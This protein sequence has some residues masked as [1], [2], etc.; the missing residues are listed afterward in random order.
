MEKS[1]NLSN[2]AAIKIFEG[3]VESAAELA[4]GIYKG[5]KAAVKFGAT[6]VLGPWGSKVSDGLFL[7]T[8]FAIDKST[9]G[10]NEAAKDAIRKAIVTVIFDEIKIK[11]LGNKTISDVLTKSTTKVIGDSRL[12]PILDD[13]LKNPEL[14]KALMSVFAKSAAHGTVE[15]SKRGV[16][17]LIRAFEESL[18]EIAPS[19][20]GEIIKK[21]E[22]AQPQITS[23][24]WITPKKDK[25]QVGD[26]LTAEFTIA[27]KGNAS[28]TFDI[29]TVGGRLNGGCPQD[30]CPDFDWHPKD[31]KDPPITLK[32][33]DSYPYKG[34]LKLKAPGNYHF[35]TAYRTKDG[36]NT[37]IP[38]AL[39]V[40]NTKD[41]VV[42]PPRIT[43]EIEGKYIFQDYPEAYI[44][45]E[46]NGTYEGK[47]WTILWG[48]EVAFG[49]DYHVSGKWK[50]EGKELLIF[51][52]NIN[53][54]LLSFFIENNDTIVERGGATLWVKEGATYHF[55][56]ERV[57]G[58]YSYAGVKL[59]LKP[60]GTCVFTVENRRQI[61]G[62][63]KINGNTIQ[64]SLNPGT[65][66]FS[67]LAW[68]A[69]KRIV[70][71]VRDND[72]LI[73]IKLPVNTKWYRKK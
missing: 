4:G 3:E 64:I 73:Q 8:D 58:I 12:Y 2:E 20:S 40:K 25:Y 38:T 13:I 36:W 10:L 30:K 21:V 67:D 14:K 57:S 55:S 37:A 65:I 62:T 52:K 71:K 5:S 29:L 46:K 18:K 39:G 49:S 23:S 26:I 9:K 72:T 54:P 41:I 34:N 6:V 22:A 69:S 17:D 56:Q 31:T 11:D 63:W 32:P 1:G 61:S 35:F 43:S 28:I 45:L 60:N 70:F 33:G 15:L 44:M 42:R 66:D 47:G 68:G 50:K 27:N 7:A 59:D 19:K 51:R 24:L 53:F 16:E 48:G